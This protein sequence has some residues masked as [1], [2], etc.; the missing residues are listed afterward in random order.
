MHLSDL[1]TGIP[2]YLLAL[3]MEP[4]IGTQY[5][6]VPNFLV[7]DYVYSIFEDFSLFLKI[8]EGL[9]LAQRRLRVRKISFLLPFH[10]AQ[11]QP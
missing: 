11:L 10:C 6:I 5:F 8:A 7:L 2:E 3:C 9:K 4:L 1:G